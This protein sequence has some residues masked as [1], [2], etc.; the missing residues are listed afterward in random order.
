[1]KQVA[2]VIGILGGIG[3]I[4]WAMRDR[5]VSVAISREPE[6]PAFKT[7]P[8]TTGEIARTEEAVEPHSIADITAVSGIGPVYATRLEGAGISTL[9]DLAGADASTISDVAEVSPTRAEDW[10]DQAKQRLTAGS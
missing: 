1:M 4:V 8:P 7:L 5:F 3:A 10:I 6:A 2:R 9:R